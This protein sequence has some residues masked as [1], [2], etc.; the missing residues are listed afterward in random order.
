MLKVRITSEGHGHGTYLVDDATGKPVPWVEV[1]VPKPLTDKTK[2]WTAWAI[3]K[4]ATMEEVE[5]VIGLEPGVF[6]ERRKAR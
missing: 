3:R 2:I 5:L 1:L 6:P 4:D